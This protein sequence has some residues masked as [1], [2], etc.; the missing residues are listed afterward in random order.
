MASLATHIR[1]FRNTLQFLVLPLFIVHI[2][3]C[4]Y[5]S[6]ISLPLT[7][8]SCRLKG[9]LRSAMPHAV[10]HWAGVI[11]CRCQSGGHLGLAPQQDC[12]APGGGHLILGRMLL[13][14]VPVSPL[15]SLIFDHPSSIV[16]EFHLL[17]L[18]VTSSQYCTSLSCRQAT[19]IDRRDYI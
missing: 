19:I 10:W 4:F 14:V 2:F 18:S 12:V 16:Y 3:F 8:S 1:L 11:A 15:V 13:G 9:C 6:S 7:Y 17:Y 5:F